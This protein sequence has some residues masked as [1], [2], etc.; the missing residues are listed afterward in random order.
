QHKKTADNTLLDVA[1]G[2]GG[3]LTHLLPHFTCEGLDMDTGML[4]VA[5]EKFPAVT[6]HQADMTNFHLG[7][8]YGVVTCMFSSIGY[9]QTVEA[10]NQTLKNFAEHVVSGGVVVIE[11]WF[12]S[13]L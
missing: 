5:R 12:S 3:H 8:Q 2:T 7:K 10:L 11:P 9:V 13:V 1:C 4:A 6:F